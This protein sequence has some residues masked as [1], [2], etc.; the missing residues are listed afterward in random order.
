MDIVRK[1][2]EIPVNAH[3]K[4]LVPISIIDSGEIGDS[5]HFILNDPFNRENMKKIK[6]VNE[7]SRIYFE[8]REN[9]EKKKEK[10]ENEKKLEEIKET[11]EEK[12]EKKIK[13]EEKE[14]KE[15]NLLKD[16]DDSKLP[17]DKKNFLKKMRMKINKNIEKNFNLI[18]KE[19]TAF[20]SNVNSEKTKRITKRKFKLKR[21]KHKKIDIHNDK[22]TNKE[23]EKYEEDEEDYNSWLLNQTAYDQHKKKKK[24]KQMF[25]WNVFN[26]DALY[27]AHKK[28]L[29][30]MVTEKERVPE[31]QKK[32]EKIKNLFENNTNSKQNFEK[33]GDNIRRGFIANN[34][35]S[36][37]NQK[38]A[39][40]V[41]EMNAR[42][43]HILGDKSNEDEERK[44][45]LVKMLKKQLERREKFKRRRG[46][47]PD[48]K[49]TYI[50]ERNRGYNDKLYRY[51]GNYVR[52]IESKLERGG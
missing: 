16:I 7:H 43:Q 1:I 51:F 33:E 18:S 15:A 6:E 19:K 5:K 26:E 24:R 40:T 20:I 27:D 13:I 38:E 50:N 32:L 37:L 30:D 46:M 29:K 36:S 12:F 25:G 49:V 23:K 31:E 44:E 28:R 42:V 48:S 45:R 10:K 35:L 47:D 34:M 11:L 17:E 52:G 39:G 41:A 14:Y 2:A 9:Y 22:L 8:D 21:K 4:P 3:E